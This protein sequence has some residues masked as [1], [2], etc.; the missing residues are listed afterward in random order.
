VVGPDMDS[1]RRC[2]RSA[3]AC[4]LVLADL[5]LG[6]IATPPDA[7]DNFFRDECGVKKSGF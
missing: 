2:S 5:N 7:F 6:R 1:L 3:G 4:L